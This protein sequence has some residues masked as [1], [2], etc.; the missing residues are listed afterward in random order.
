MPFQIKKNPKKVQIMGSGSGWELAPINSDAVIYALND[1]VFYERYK[2]QPDILFIMDILDEKP[3]IVAGVNNLGD[4]IKRINDLKCPL[5]A[6][7]KYA[8]I[9]LSQEFP[10]KECVKRFGQPYFSN[11]ISYMIAYALMQGVEEIEVYGVN[12]ASSSEYFYEKAGVE[13]WLGIAIGMGVKLTI[14]GERSELLTNKKRMGGGLLY[15]YN[16][17]YETILEVEAK[18]GTQI[19]KKLLLPQASFSRTI[20]KINHDTKQSIQ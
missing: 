8:E 10:L 4:V 6:P 15:G 9:P 17:S 14:H 11:T 1:Y 16:Q 3:Q 2:I 19:I 12:Q 20:R 7:F 18:F 5:I 13:Y